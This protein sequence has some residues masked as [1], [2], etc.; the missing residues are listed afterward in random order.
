MVQLLPIIIK[1]YNS[2]VCLKTIFSPLCFYTVYPF[3][4]PFLF[5]L[6]HHQN[7]CFHYWKITSPLL[8][9]NS[10]KNKPLLLY[11]RSLAEEKDRITSQLKLNKYKIS[12]SFHEGDYVFCK[13]NSYTPGTSCVLRTTFS[14][15]LYVFLQV[16]PTS[17]VLQRLADGFTT[18]YNE[19]L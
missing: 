8:K 4:I 6:I 19:T 7:S 2:T 5:S 11:Q 10:W 1:Q 12:T 14:H 3:P 9:R 13:D 17:L 16:K 15:D 18:I